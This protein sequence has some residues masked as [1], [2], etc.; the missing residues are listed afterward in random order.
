MAAAIALVDERTF[1]YCTATYLS[2][3]LVSET[4]LQLLPH[5]VLAHA[6]TTTPTL[7]A[8]ASE[9]TKELGRLVK[10]P[11]TAAISRSLWCS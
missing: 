5:D 3:T 6:R 7:S 8:G 2:V 9:N 11:S 10:F 4:G 1:E